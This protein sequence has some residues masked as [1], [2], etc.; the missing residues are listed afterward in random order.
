MKKTLVILMATSLFAAA[1]P[2]MA[3]D[4][5]AMHDQHDEQCAKECEMLLRDCAHEVDSIQQR[6]QRIQSEIKDKGATT[7]SLDELKILNQRLKETNA[8]M[9]SLQKPGH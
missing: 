9:W 5:G 3:V 2:A 4:H 6:I 7:Y 8:L 1:V